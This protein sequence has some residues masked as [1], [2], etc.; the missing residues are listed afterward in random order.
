MSAK[1]EKEL[2]KQLPRTNCAPAARCGRGRPRS[3]RK[4]V[5]Q[6]GPPGALK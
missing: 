1:R 3:Q 4:V 2:A 5:F 6:T